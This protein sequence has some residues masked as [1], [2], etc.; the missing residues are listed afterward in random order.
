MT[1]APILCLATR[2]A[3]LRLRR[4]I[5]MYRTVHWLGRG[6]RQLPTMTG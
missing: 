2:G 3:H 1:T 6:E 5:L 4:Q